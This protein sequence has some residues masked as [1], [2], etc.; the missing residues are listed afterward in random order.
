MKKGVLFF[1]ICFAMAACHSN[2]GR[3]AAD[4]HFSPEQQADK[5][6]ER[7]SEEL[8][9]TVQQQ[10]EVKAWLITSQQKRKKILEEKKGE[11]KNM[12]EIVRKHREEMTEQLKKILTEEQYRQYERYEKERRTRHRNPE[13][14]P[15]QSPEHRFHGFLD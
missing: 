7:M 3:S 10:K 9:L 1:I 13:R 6:L 2:S 5:M 12:R 4:E 14:I 11:R 8:K 15:D